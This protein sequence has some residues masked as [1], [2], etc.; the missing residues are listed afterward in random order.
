VA[1]GFSAL[2]ASVTGTGN[3]AVGNQALQNSKSSGNTAVGSSS[4][5]T[6]TSGSQNT[7][8]GD[9]SLFS[10]TTGSNNV[11]LGWSA[12]FGAT[13]GNQASITDTYGVFLGAFAS[14]DASVPNTTTLSNVIAIG[15]GATVA[16]NNTAVI[17]GGNL[18]NVIFG[19]ATTGPQITWGTGVP[20]VAPASGAGLHFSIG[21]ATGAS[22]YNY[23]AGAWHAIG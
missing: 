23:S 18:T 19:G 15:A 20:T 11:A 12:G 16:T 22:L 2:N 1:I 13:G 21:G 14:R 8:V 7:A 10:V 6:Q 4:L 9:N 3:T 17:G 5:N